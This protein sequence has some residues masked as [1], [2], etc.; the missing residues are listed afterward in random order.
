MPS[1][2]KYQIIYCDPPW[3]YN[4][5]NND[6]TRFGKGLWSAYQPM[7]ESELLELAP[8]VQSL[9]ADRCLMFMWVTAPHMATAIRLLDAW[10]FTY[11]TV[12]FVWEKVD[13]RGNSRKLPGFYTASNQEFLILGRK[14]GKHRPAVKMLSQVVKHRCTSNHSEKPAIFRELIEVMYPD[15]RRIELF[16]RHTAPDWDAWGNEVGKLDTG[17]ASFHDM[18][19]HGGLTG[20]KADNHKA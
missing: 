3:W 10:G 19:I 8:F 5:R 6:G 7:K 1:G 18:I 16:A 11:V 17:Q 12:A 9:A 2:D 20:G 13:K 14:G 4:K 15:R